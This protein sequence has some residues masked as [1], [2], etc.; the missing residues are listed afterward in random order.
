MSG[1]KR[2]TGKILYYLRGARI[3][4]TPRNGWLK[5]RLRNGVVV[6]GRNLPGHG[7]RGI[8]LDRDMIE[9]E[10]NHL[11]MFLEPG[12]VFIDIGANTGIYTL[13]AAQKLGPKGIVIA[14]EPT[15]FVF[16]SLVRNVR[17]NGF[18]NVRLRNLCCGKSTGLANFYQN[19][20][21]PVAF[22]L[23]QHDEKAAPLSVL[24]VALDDL[25]EWEM[26]GRVDF[27]KMDVEGAEPEV[28]AGARKTIQTYRPVILAEIHLGDVNLEVEDYITISAPN[29]PNKMLVPR[30]RTKTIETAM[31][32]GWSILD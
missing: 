28:I 23:K 19:F 1:G 15:P 18:A 6:Y 17:E 31:Q 16:T 9:P 30:E 10:F 13:K 32:L 11:D 29:S 14:V 21:R 20:D 25:L 22:S 26:P 7:G 5:S 2:G 12:A 24:C 27:I 3:M 8:Y 4:L